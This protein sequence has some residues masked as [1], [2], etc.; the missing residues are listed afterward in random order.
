MRPDLAAARRQPQRRPRRV[1]ADRCAADAKHRRHSPAAVK[2]IGTLEDADK[3]PRRVPVPA[4][5]PA[6]D[7]VQADRR[8]AGWQQ[9]GRRDAGPG[10]R[11]QEAGREAAEARRHSADSGAGVGTDA[12]DAQLKAWLAD[13]RFKVSTGCR[14]WTSSQPLEDMSLDEWRELNRVRVKNL[15]TAMRTLY[16]SVAGPGRSWSPPRAWAVCMATAMWR[17]SP[18]GRR[19]GGLHQGL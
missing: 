8:G 18:L 3:M 19:G 7:V 15:Y 10:R 11:R 2:T 1:S 4:L 14:R 17:G 13:G 12:L 16:D 5:R 6:L 9:P